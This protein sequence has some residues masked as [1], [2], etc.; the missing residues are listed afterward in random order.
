MFTSSL[1]DFIWRVLSHYS[2]VLLDLFKMMDLH[3]LMSPNI[4]ISLVICN[5]F[6]YPNLIWLI[7]T[8]CLFGVR[9]RSEEFKQADLV[10]FGEL[11][12]SQGLDNE[13]ELGHLLHK[14]VKRWSHFPNE[15]M[16]DLVKFGEL[17][18]SQGLDNEEEL[19]H[20]L[21][22]LVGS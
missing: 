15:S 8:N 9:D 19:G 22:K 16:A 5:T 14:L 20:P 6:P 13:K 12:A 7:V 21:H 10:K 17:V 18:A 11:V 2:V 1:Q 4:T 3:Q